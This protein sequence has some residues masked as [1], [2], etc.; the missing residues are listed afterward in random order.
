MTDDTLDLTVLD[1]EGEEVDDAEVTVNGEE[2]GGSGSGGPLTENDD[3]E[4]EPED[5]QPIRASGGLYI[6]E[7]EEDPDDGNLW[8]RGDL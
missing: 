3:D 1:D 5:G 4:L 8:I 6:P 7:L 2:V